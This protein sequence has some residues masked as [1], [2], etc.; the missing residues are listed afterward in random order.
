MLHFSNQKKIVLKKAF[1]RNLAQL[2]LGGGTFD[3]CDL[4][5]SERFDKTYCLGI[6]HLSLESHIPKEWL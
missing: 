6:E 2:L 5:D 1:M 3:V 4:P